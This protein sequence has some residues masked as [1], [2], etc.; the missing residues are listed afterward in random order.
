MLRAST[1]VSSQRPEV[2]SLT[3]TKRA[4]KTQ[5]KRKKGAIWSDINKVVE[6]EV[7]A[8]T[9]NRNTGFDNHH[10]TRMLS[11]ELWNPAETFQQKF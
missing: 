1:Q 6:E 3:L 2:A 11:R 8:L 5:Y 7:P 9:P 4:N 10:Q